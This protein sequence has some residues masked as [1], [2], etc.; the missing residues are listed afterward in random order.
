MRTDVGSL[1]P[2]AFNRSRTRIS[3]SFHVATCCTPSLVTMVG[4]RSRSSPSTHPY[5]NRPMSHIQKSFTAGL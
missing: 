4:L 5:W 3:A 1:R 2:A